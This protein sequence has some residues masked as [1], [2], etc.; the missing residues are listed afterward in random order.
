[1]L[2]PER[3]LIQGLWLFPRTRIHPVYTSTSNYSTSLSTDILELWMSVISIKADHCTCIPLAVK[4]SNRAF[5]ISR[6]K[7]ERAYQ[8]QVKTHSYEKRLVITHLT[9]YNHDSL[10]TDCKE[11]LKNPTNNLKINMTRHK[12][13]CA[14][15]CQPTRWWVSDFWLIHWDPLS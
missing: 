2:F 6:L 14:L 15:T 1:M 4:C 8:Q 10:R 12:N 7:D 13:V 3:K 9:V 11:F 5:L